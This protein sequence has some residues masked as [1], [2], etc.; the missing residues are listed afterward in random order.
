M[1]STRKTDS[2]NQN[3][4]Q[5][6]SYNPWNLLFNSRNRSESESSASSTNSEN[7]QTGSQFGGYQRPARK[8]NEEYL[9]M[10][11][12]STSFINGDLKYEF[13]STMKALVI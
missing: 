5:N 10:L 8:S 12:N 2:K 7:C 13:Y 11:T 6:T 1:D 9:Y 4:S 3:R